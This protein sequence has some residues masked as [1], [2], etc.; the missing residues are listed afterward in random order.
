MSHLLRFMSANEAIK[1]LQGERLYNQTVHRETGH[2]S[3]SVGFCFAVLNALHPELIY[4]HAR[5]LSGITCMN[6]CLI[7][8]LK[9]GQKWQKN[10]AR[11]SAGMRSEYAT[12]DYSLDDFEDWAMYTPQIPQPPEIHL[13]A[14]VSTNWTEPVLATKKEAENVAHI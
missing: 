12:Q 13:Y 9:K 10:L 5:Y 4:V 11:F 14:P 3:D 2:S 1:L 8:S 6:V 7:G